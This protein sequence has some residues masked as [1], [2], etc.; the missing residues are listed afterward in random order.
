MYG[1]A[2]VPKN[3][4]YLAR[5]SAAEMLWRGIS[6]VEGALDWKTQSSCHFFWYFFSIAIRVSRFSV[7]G[8]YTCQWQVHSKGT[9]EERE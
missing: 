9:W 5:T 3:L 4:G 2:I 1:Y 8:E 7:Y 6:E